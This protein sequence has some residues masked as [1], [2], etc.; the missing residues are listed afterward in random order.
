M[1]INAQAII[2]I[3]RQ[4]LC[5]KASKETREAWQAVIAELNETDPILAKACV[6]SCVYRG[7]CPEFS[8]CGFYNTQKFTAARNRYINHLLQDDNEPVWRQVYVIVYCSD[9]EWKTRPD[10]FAT[11]E[12]AEEAA[13]KMPNKTI[14]KLCHQYKAN[15]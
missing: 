8:T 6:P 9:G 13:S 3:S 1:I 14:V 7:L 5:S 11:R 12:E 4:R 10:T 15:D 2:N